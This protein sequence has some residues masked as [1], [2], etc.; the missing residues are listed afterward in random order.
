MIGGEEEWEFIAT[1][2]GR[3]GWGHHPYTQNTMAVPVSCWDIWKTHLFKCTDRLCTSVH[4][5]NMTDARV[6]G[7]VFS[8]LLLLLLLPLLILGSFLPRRE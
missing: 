6:Y 2:K 8:L 7:P 4:R 3:Y 1:A 5:D